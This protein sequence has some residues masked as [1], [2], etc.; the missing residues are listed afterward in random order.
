MAGSENLGASFTIDT[1]NLKA[2]LAQA[3]RLIR[4]SESEFK[5][6]AAGMDDWTKS[7]DGINAKIKQLNNT[8]DLQRKKVDALQK[9]YSDLISKGLDPTSKQAVELRTKINNETTALN[10]NEK[11]LKQQTAALQNLGNESEDAANSTDDL[12]DSTKSTGSGFAGLKGSAGIAVAAIAAVAAAA[13]AGVKAL[14]DLAESTRETR[15]AMSRLET[16]FTTAGH[17]AEDA[18]NTYKT[19]YGVLGDA[20]RASEA[21]GHLALLADNTQDLE[22]WTDIAT[23]VYAQF[24]DSLPIEGL[25]EAANETAKVGDVTGVLADALNWAGVNEEDFQEKLDE[26]STEQERQQLIT[27]TLNGLYADQ[28][29]KFK[30][31]NKDIIAANEA[32][33]DLTQAQADLGAAIEPINTKLTEFKTNII[34]N[35]TPTL[36]LLADDFTAVF[37]GVSGS[38][39]K[40]S[41]DITNTFNNILTDLSTKLPEYGQKGI[42][43]ITSLMNGISEM[44]PQLLPMA[45]TG[46]TNLATTITSE[47]NLDKMWE[48]GKKLFSS[49]GDG[50]EKAIPILMNAIPKIVGNI[51]K[52]FAEDPLYFIN[53]GVEF[54][55]DIISGL[56][57]GIKDMFAQ[58][59]E[60]LTDIKDTFIEKGLP[61]MKEVGKQLLNGIWEGMKGIGG[62]MWDGIKSVGNSIVDGFKT[63]F[64]INSPSRLF[65]NQ[66]GSY[67]GE[68]MALGI[69]DGFDDKIGNVRKSIVKSMSGIGS[70]IDVGAN[71]TGSAATGS[72]RGIVVNQYNTYSQAHSR[73]ELFKSKQQTA[74]A[75]RLAMAGGV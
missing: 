74:A 37:N 68:G 64:G 60:M 16:G 67:M 24:G 75:V 13:I 44:L 10:K 39:Q 63:F 30:E 62:A 69:V 17:S 52:K 50:L 41:T 15:T 23:G 34:E 9:Q 54:I 73:Y 32:Q 45:V 36:T 11:E 28:S 3:N 42:D 22:K 4:E 29:E 49:L 12:A 55:G 65:R 61:K 71:G 2:G 20:D 40:L 56:W 27:E 47:E 25:T 33:A 51:A 43:I 48:S 8:T 7:S 5:A 6:A 14:L 26:C 59:P 70:D 18:T 31:L 72:A 35:V 38:T 53:T 1:T 66:L 19:L 46:I 58:I 21:A 57:Q